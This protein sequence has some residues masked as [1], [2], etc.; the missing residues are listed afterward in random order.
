VPLQHLGQPP[1]LDRDGIMPATPELV[2]DLC[3]L[4]PHP[5]R[6]RDA[7]DPETPSPGFRADVRE[8]GRELARLLLLAVGPG[9]FTSPPV[10]RMV[11]PSQ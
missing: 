6:D 5:F 9:T 2:L 8:K 7:L 10:S 11:V 1:P 4:R 3:Q